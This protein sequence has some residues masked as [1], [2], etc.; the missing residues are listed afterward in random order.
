[1]NRLLNVGFQTA[2]EWILQG[3]RLRFDIRQHGSQENV[4]YAFV[5]DGTVKYVGKSTQKLRAR[6]AGYS[7]PGPTSSTNQRVKQLIVSL[8]MSGVTVEVLA[9]PDSGLMHYGP[10]HLNLAAGLEDSIIRQLAPEWNVAVKPLQAT[11]LGR[12]D[13]EVRPSTTAD[14]REAPKETSVPD[15]PAI[16]TFEFT[17]QPSYREKGFFNGG[18]ASSSLLGAAGDNIEIYFADEPRPLLGLINRSST[19][20]GSPRIFGGPELARRF[21]TIATGAAM[22]VD[23]LSPTSVRVHVKSPSDEGHGASS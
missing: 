3:G 8:L 9:L 18:V 15:F 19:G 22:R 6:M 23:V 17:L 13:S 16:G 14:E 1:M 2:G 7:S 20:N 11:A 4:L 5:C 10:F 21:Q 12:A